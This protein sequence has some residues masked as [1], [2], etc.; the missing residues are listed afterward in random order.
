MA[1]IK[2]LAGDSLLLSITL[3][4]KV[5]PTISLSANDYTQYLLTVLGKI[6]SPYNINVTNATIAQLGLGSYAIFG[7]TKD[8]HVKSFTISDT[9]A[10]IQSA[11]DAGSL[12]NLKNLKNIYITGKMNDNLWYKFTISGQSYINN[13]GIFNLFKSPIGLSVIKSKASLAGVLASDRLV[14]D[15]SIEDSAEDISDAILSGALTASGV[16][17]KLR[18]LVITD[19]GSQIVIIGSNYDAAKNILQKIIFNQ[20]ILIT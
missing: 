5:T 18:S 14:L 12:G 16:G 19:S 3:T 20:F 9:A 8:T 7:V 6:Q 10:H 2:A 1:G 13:N 17:Q 4:D 11:L 15:Y